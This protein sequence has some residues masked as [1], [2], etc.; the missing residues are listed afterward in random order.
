M[1][2]KMWKFC[3]LQITV[4]TDKLESPGSL[5]DDVPISE[6]SD[7]RIRQTSRERPAS[8]KTT[9]DPAPIS[10]EALLFGLSVPS[11]VPETN[12]YELWSK[13][14]ISSPASVDNYSAANNLGTQTMPRTPDSVTAFVSS[15]TIAHAQSPHAGSSGLAFPVAAEMATPSVAANNQV[16]V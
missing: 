14:D 1:H 3:I 12:N 4:S 7:E 8:L 16:G 5:I 2:V 9:E 13:S 15:P 6:P 10:L 11:V